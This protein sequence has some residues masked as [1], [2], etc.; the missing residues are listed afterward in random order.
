MKR[1]NDLTQSVANTAAKQLELIDRPWVSV[2]FT[3]ESP[4]LS[5]VTRFN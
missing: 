1:T 2:S 4:F 3:P 5:A